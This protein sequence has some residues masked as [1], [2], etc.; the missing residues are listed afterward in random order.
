MSYCWHNLNKKC[1][2][3]LDFLEHIVDV[4]CFS[5]L[6]WGILSYN[7]TL[8]S[9]IT[10]KNFWT[11]HIVKWSFLVTWMCMKPLGLSSNR[12]PIMGLWTSAL[13]SLFLNVGGASR[14]YKASESLKPSFTRSRW[15]ELALSSAFKYECWNIQSLALHISEVRFLWCPGWNF[16][17]CFQMLYLEQGP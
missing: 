4:F 16:L 6:L 13:Y 14:P 7:F 1:F 9:L 15:S 2:V 12:Q 5:F 3:F 10:A 8:T 11:T 17:E